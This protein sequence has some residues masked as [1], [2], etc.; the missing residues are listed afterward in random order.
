M[1]SSPSTES[2]LYFGWLSKTYQRMFHDIYKSTL[3]ND[4]NVLNFFELFAFV[5]LGAFSE[6]FSSIASNPGYC[7]QFCHDFFLLPPRLSQEGS[8]HRSQ[9]HLHHPQNLCCILDVWQKHIRECSRI[10]TRALS[11]MISMFWVSLNC[12]F[13][14]GI[15]W[16]P[17]FLLQVAHVIIVG[18]F[19]MIS[20]LTTQAVSSR[21]SESWHCFQLCHITHVTWRTF[22]YTCL[23]HS[24]KNIIFGVCEDPRWKDPLNNWTWQ[25]SGTSMARWW[26]LDF[27]KNLCSCLFAASLQQ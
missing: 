9:C 14:R 7:R 26:C 15:L 18:R 19:D 3:L 16:I 23:I 25:I 22:V 2:L 24:E 1:P 27:A 13:F 4:L 11:S 5:F 6:F 8:L 20:S 21:S 10:F 17:S 12:F